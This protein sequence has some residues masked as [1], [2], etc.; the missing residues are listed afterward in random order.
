[1]N[2]YYKYCFGVINPNQQKQQE[3]NL[4][5]N[6]HQGKYIKTLPLHESQQI[7]IDNENELKIKLEIFITH[8]FFMELLSLGENVKIIKPKS[9][10][11][12]LKASYKN[13]LENYL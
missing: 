2:L 13:A 7:L 10:I 12:D 5:F 1:M 11:R 3:I 6:P 8:D 4:S 9:L